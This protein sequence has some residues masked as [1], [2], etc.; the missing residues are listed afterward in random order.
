M[1]KIKLLFT[2]TATASG[3]RNGHTEASGLPP[4]TP[5][6]LGVRWISSPS[7]TKRML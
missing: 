6:V 3:G 4:V 7:S 1:D 5:P 2:A